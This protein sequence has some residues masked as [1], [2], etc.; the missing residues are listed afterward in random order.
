MF[1][2]F[3]ILTAFSAFSAKN[4]TIVSEQS[5]TFNDNMFISSSEYGR[6]EIYWKIVQRVVVLGSFCFLFVS[7]MGAIIIPKRAFAS[8]QEW[9]EFINLC[10]SKLQ[11]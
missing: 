9:K 3:L 2:L 10:R 11:K 4:K 1:I 5:M 8:N 7:Q 6:S